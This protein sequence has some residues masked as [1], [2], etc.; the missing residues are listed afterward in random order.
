M[1]AQNLTA[2]VSSHQ[3]SQDI[4][5][6]CH[7]QWFKIW[8]EGYDQKT[9]QWCSEKI[10]QNNGILSVKLPGNLV[11]GSYLV[12]SEL[13]A[14]HEADKSPPEPQF[15]IGCAQIY[16]SSTGTALPSET[17]KIPGHV[18]I[19]DPSMLY[20]IYDGMKAT[21]PLSGPKRYVSGLSNF[22]KVDQQPPQKEGL[23]PA[24]AILTNAN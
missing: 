19:R 22:T 15:Y 24:N 17:V 1:K 9:S 8:D 6:T 3:S 12:R 11:G 14:L 4:L 5:L 23:L 20:N 7:L 2:D 10:I 16:L 13:L 21:Y 18:S